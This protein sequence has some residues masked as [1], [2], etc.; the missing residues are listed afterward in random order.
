MHPLRRSWLACATVL[1]C[2]VAL[3]R[4]HVP[5]LR[6]DPG[7]IVEGIDP[8]PCPSALWHTVVV[9]GI[10]FDD[11]YLQKY[12]TVGSNI[13]IYD[14]VG[15]P[16]SR[17]GMWE[18]HDGGATI[19]CNVL[20]ILR[21]GVHLDLMVYTVSDNWGPLVP[22]S[23]D[24]CDSDGGGDPPPAEESIARQTTA[25]QINSQEVLA[26]TSSCGTSGGTSGGGGGDGETCTEEYGEID[27]SYDG[28]ATWQVWW[29][30]WYTECEMAE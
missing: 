8:V 7:D 14:V 1:M 3:L 15:T 19:S 12:Q 26:S 4:L 18:W 11:V 29:E 13:A 28:G 21:F 24:E 30:G 9:D 5:T 23:D 25:P 17:D 27:I 6:A 16:V 22:V 10:W 20:H 2:L